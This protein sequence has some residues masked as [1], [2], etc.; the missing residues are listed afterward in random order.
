MSLITS[1][2]SS[3]SAREDINDFVSHINRGLASPNK[4]TRDL[5]L[6]ACL[7]VY[8]KDTVYNVKNFTAEAIAKIEVN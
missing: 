5:V 8:D 7:I 4:I 2:W 3:K 1:K 6:K